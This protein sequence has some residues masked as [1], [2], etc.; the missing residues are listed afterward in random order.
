MRVYDSYLNLNQKT[1]R[2]RYFEKLQ[3]KELPI[4]PFENQI[5]DIDSITCEK[6]NKTK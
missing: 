3:Y 4:E 1:D 6:I 5:I 2:Y